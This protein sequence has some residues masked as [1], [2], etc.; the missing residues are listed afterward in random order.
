MSLEIFT[1]LNLLKP[2]L[3][4]YK[5][6]NYLHEKHR[7]LI[8]KIDRVIKSMKKSGELEKSR[9]I[10]IKQVFQEQQNI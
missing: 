5:L 7:S 2:T 1:Y 3:E 8:P 9:N 6:Y 10:I 4:R